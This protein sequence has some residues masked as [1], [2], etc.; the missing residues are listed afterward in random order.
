MSRLYTGAELPHPKPYVSPFFGTNFCHSQSIDSPT[1]CNKMEDEAVKEGWLIGMPQDCLALT[2]KNKDFAWILKDISCMT[3]S[4]DQR[5][6]LKKKII[7][8]EEPVY[9][10]L[11]PECKDGE[12]IDVEGLW[13]KCARSR[14]VIKTGKYSLQKLPPVTRKAPRNHKVEGELEGASFVIYVCENFA[15]EFYRGLEDNNKTPRD[16][17]QLDMIPQA[18]YDECS[19][20]NFK[21]DE[22]EDLKE[23][24][25]ISF[26]SDKIKNIRDLLNAEGI[27]TLAI[28]GIEIEIFYDDMGENEELRALM[29]AEGWGNFPTGP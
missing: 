14:K 25:E 23:P 27:A 11:D 16:E 24:E 9:E 8:L 13:L 2:E 7:T 19:Y 22:G 12:S 1:C 18:D 29:D 21:D 28:Y 5:R 4:T 6:F 20:F 3:C 17:V 15:R 10:Q 26:M